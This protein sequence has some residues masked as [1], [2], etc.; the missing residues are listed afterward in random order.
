MRGT[1]GAAALTFAVLPILVFAAV[2]ADAAA[3]ADGNADA[4]LF[5]DRCGGCHLENGFGT[6]VL[7]R[8][9]PEGQAE[10]EHRTGLT[11]AFVT[12]AV[13]RGIGSMPQIR[14]AELPDDQLA[15][16]A[17]YLGAKK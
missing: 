10:L 14:A 1:Y 16:I 8:R 9:V 5:R 12:L 2:G 4:A 17:A 15:R 3:P 13:R 7:A 6:R 11:P